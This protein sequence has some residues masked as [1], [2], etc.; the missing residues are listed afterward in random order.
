MLVTQRAEA[1]T[2]SCRK[3]REH[4]EQ[5]D[6]RRKAHAAEQRSLLRQELD[7]QCASKHEQEATLRG[8]A[9]V[10]EQT[11]L[12]TLAEVPA[13]LSCKTLRA[14]GCRV[15]MPACIGLL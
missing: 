2:L 7:R 14:C 10:H 11:L 9:A 12:A 8:Q 15:C 1:A 5:E 3:Q 4:D 6:M 13:G